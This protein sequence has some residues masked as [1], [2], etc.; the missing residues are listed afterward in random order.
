M[1]AKS[2]CLPVAGSA[3]SRPG[4]EDTG[5]CYG[6][7]RNPF[8]GPKTWWMEIQVREHGGTFRHQGVSSTPPTPLWVMKCEMLTYLVFITSLCG[9]PRSG[10]YHKRGDPSLREELAGGPAAA[11]HKG[12]AQPWALDLPAE[13]PGEMVSVFGVGTDQ[14]PVSL[15]LKW[16]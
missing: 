9:R 6:G 4:R 12:G 14:Q 15:A 10:P 2:E 16:R 1:F 13:V 11:E 5:P 7:E 3:L 8:E